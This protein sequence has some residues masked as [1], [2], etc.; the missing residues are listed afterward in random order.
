MRRVVASSA[1]TWT[2]LEL[3]EDVE[4]GDIHG[5]VERPRESRRQ[6]LVRA[7]QSRLLTITVPLVHAHTV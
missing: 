4:Q 5:V 1:G 6:V 7:A 2:L 3:A